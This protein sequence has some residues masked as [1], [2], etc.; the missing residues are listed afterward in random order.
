MK[1]GSSHEGDDDIVAE[2]NM[3]PLIDVSLVLLIIFMVLTPVLVRSQIKVDLPSSTSAKPS[4]DDPLRFD[5]KVDKGGAVYLDEQVI[6][7]ATLGS[8]LTRRVSGRED[9]VVVLQADRT[10]MFDNVVHV[11]DEIKKAGITQIGI[12]VVPERRTN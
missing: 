5:V 1:G 6:D 11:M 4:Q 12:G 9:A 2:I 3:I 8:E 7:P 10:I